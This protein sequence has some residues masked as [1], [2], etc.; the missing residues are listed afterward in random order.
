MKALHGWM[1]VLLLAAFCAAACVGSCAASGEASG[2]DQDISPA[3]L[4]HRADEA[5]GAECA[6]LSMLAARQALED[7]NRLFGSGDVKAAHHAI[8]TSWR[9]ARR[10]V[11][12]S[13]R[14]RKSEKATEINLRELIRRMDDISQTLDSVDRPHLSQVL[15]ELEKQRQRLLQALFGAAG[16]GAPEKKP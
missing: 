15:A 12:C 3:D 14:A 8:D 5:S 1:R 10:S 6:R 9:Y 16:G 2:V 7:A 13:L 4:Q 11:D